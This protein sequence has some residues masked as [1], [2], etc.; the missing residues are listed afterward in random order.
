MEQQS[1]LR[2]E[3][4]APDGSAKGRARPGGRTARVRA[5]VLAAVIDEIAENGYA[6]L[7]MDRVAARAGVGRTT[8]YRRWGTPEGLAADLLALIGEEAMPMPDT[9]SLEGD[10][11]AFAATTLAAHQDERL[12]AAIQGVISAASREPA[13]GNALQTFYNDRNREAAAL[14]DRAVTRGELPPGTDGV[15]F[16]RMFAAP[17]CYRATITREPVDEGVAERTLAMVLAAARAG[18]FVR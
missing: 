4:S 3:P 9:G 16:F 5:A 11:R 12:Q 15:E 13:A 14:I 10:L 8:V 2:E 17:F 1:R 6:A 7:N 18:V